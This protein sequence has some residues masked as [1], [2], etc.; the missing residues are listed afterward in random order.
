MIHKCFLLSHRADILWCIIGTESRYPETDYSISPLYN[1]TAASHAIKINTYCIPFPEQSIWKLLQASQAVKE[2]GN[3]V[4]TVIVK[5][6]TLVYAVLYTPWVLLNV[7]HVKYTQLRRKFPSL[8]FVSP[9]S[10]TLY[11]YSTWLAACSMLVQS[12]LQLT[13]NGLRQAQVWLIQLLKQKVQS[14]SLPHKAHR[15]VYLGLGICFKVKQF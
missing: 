13:S 11:A 2:N 5:L 12:I 10:P 8:D 6:V 7:I 9:F 15:T 1:L 3:L 14:N 4:T